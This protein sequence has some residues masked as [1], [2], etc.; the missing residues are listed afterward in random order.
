M[1]Y[2]MSWG[3]SCLVILIPSVL[4]RKQIHPCDSGYAVANEFMAEYIAY[5]VNEMET[6]RHAESSH[7]Y[8]QM[9]FQ[10]HTVYPYWLS[11]YLAIVM[12]DKHITEKEIS[13]HQQYVFSTIR[14]VLA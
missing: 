13:S 2:G 3:I 7:L 1:R 10:H 4:M 11:R 12:D 14:E 5:T 6:F 8:L 9:A